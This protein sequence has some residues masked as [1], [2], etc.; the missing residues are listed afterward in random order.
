VY[1]IYIVVIAAAAAWELIA[2]L[3]LRLPIEPN[4]PLLLSQPSVGVYVMLMH[5]LCGKD[6]KLMA[7]CKITMQNTCVNE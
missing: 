5:V 4:A 7:E 3:M 1:E 6:Y 2:T